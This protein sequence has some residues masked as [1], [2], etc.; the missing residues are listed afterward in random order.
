MSPTQVLIYVSSEFGVRSGELS[1]FQ[2][3]NGGF[4]DIQPLSK[5]EKFKF[6]GFVELTLIWDSG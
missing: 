4:K 6:F 1:F 2:G 3:E 5:L